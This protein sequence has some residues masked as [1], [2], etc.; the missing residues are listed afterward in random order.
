M[1]AGASLLV[2]VQV[3]ENSRMHIMSFYNFLVV[4]FLESLGLLLLKMCLSR[5][6]DTIT[7]ICYC[8]V[9]LS[10][11]WSAHHIRCPSAQLILFTELWLIIRMKRDTSSEIHHYIDM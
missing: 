1:H 9:M 8:C 5:P 2:N 3:H 7:H 11:N 4:S 10:Y 6:N